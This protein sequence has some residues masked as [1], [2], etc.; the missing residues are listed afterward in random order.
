M[1]FPYIL[2][3]TNLLHHNYPESGKL[4]IYPDNAYI[5]APKT[6]IKCI[7]AKHIIPDYSD[8]YML[9]LLLEYSFTYNIFDDSFYSPTLHLLSLLYTATL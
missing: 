4:C 1:I 2:L 8:Y 3:K 6:T 7:Q 9:D 5:K